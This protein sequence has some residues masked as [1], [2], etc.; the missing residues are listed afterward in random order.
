MNA[1]GRDVRIESGDGGTSVRFR[2]PVPRFPAPRTPVHRRT[3]GA[4]GPVGGAPA[5]V[6]VSGDVPP[7]VH[8]AGDLDLDGV[9]AVRPALL[10]ALRPGE[11][12]VDLRG[13]GYVS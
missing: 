2:V 11:L 6:A 7:V 10:A 12:V 9:T 8:V 1:I 3:A 13:T 4:A 5:T